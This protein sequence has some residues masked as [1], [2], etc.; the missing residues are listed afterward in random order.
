M[1]RLRGFTL[2]ELLIT[3]AIGAI[4]MSIAIPNMSRFMQNDRLTSFSNAL[5]LDLMLAKST[6]VERSQAA[7]LCASSD[8]STCNSNNY[9]DGW[10][11]LTDL[12]NDGD[13]D[14][15][16]KVQQTIDG[17]VT[18]NQ[19]GLS[20]ITFDNRGFIPTDGIIGTISVCDP[21][22]VEFAR[23]LSI[24]RTGRISRGADPSCP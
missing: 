17:N 3:V 2:I 12:D 23:T 11:V 8:Q 13:T 9:A 4:L 19:A 21:R 14:D 24:S 6:A 10:I 15:L 1:N 20:R 5:V 7:V 22:G 16:V 18:Y